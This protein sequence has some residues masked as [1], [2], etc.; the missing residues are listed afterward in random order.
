[1][2]GTSE[3]SPPGPP[4]QVPPGARLQPHRGEA[5]LILGIVG[6]VLIPLGLILG[7]IAWVMGNTDLR[8][9][10]AGRTDP[11]GRGMTIA[12]R[13]LGIVSCCL[14]VI[15][16]VFVIGSAVLWNRFAEPPMS[17]TGDRG[18]IGLNID[19]SKADLEAARKNAEAARAKFLEETKKS[20]KETKK[21][22]PATK[23]PAGT[24]KAS[25]AK[26]QS[27]R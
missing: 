10:E 20:A 7:A 16:W 25:D 19:L 1:M 23:K 26:G 2:T 11:S 22:G 8:D 9:M 27:G 14:A 5:V 13:I 17:A 12:G 15:L 21:P 3:G 4:I 18:G 24:T 6:L